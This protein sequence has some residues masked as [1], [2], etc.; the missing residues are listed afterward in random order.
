VRSEAQAKNNYYRHNGI[1]EFRSQ[2]KKYLATISY[3]DS[4][5]KK[6]LN[7]I[8]EEIGVHAV[9]VKQYLK[10]YLETGCVTVPSVINVMPSDLFDHLGFRE[11]IP[12]APKMPIV[13]ADY[14]AGEEERQQKEEDGFEAWKTAC[15]L[16]AFYT[17]SDKFLGLEKKDVPVRPLW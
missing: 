12:D 13:V 1:G 10:E 9:T 8:G 16:G 7:T 4:H 14:L 17:G 2:V 3:H 15:V 6:A 11:Q 5:R